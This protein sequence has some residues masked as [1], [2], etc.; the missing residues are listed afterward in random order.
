MI[1]RPPRAT[2]TDTLVPYT[3]LFRT[4]LPRT[5][6]GEMRNRAESHVPSLH[7]GMR[8]LLQRSQ[9][10]RRGFDLFRR[11]IAQ[12]SAPQVGHPSFHRLRELLALGKQAHRIAAAVA[13]N[14][15]AFEYDRTHSRPAAR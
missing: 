8:T 9:N 14:R 3:T 7:V 2:R 4:A 5:A 11:K 10:A 13:G 15:I 1:R 6:S 12:Q